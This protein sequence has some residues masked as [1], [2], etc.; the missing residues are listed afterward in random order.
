MSHDTSSSPRPPLSRERWIITGGVQGVGFRPFVYRCAQDAGVSG[1]VANTAEGVCLEIQGTS[2]QLEA[3]RQLFHTQLPP[4]AHIEELSCSPLPV[5]DAQGFRIAPSRGGQGHS[6]RISP[7]IALC[8]DCLREITDPSNRRAGYPFTNCTNCGPRYTITR[9]IPYDRATTSMACF[10]LCPQCHAEY[11]DPADRRFH[12]QPNACPTCGPRLWLQTARGDLVGQ[13]PQ[14]MDMAAH[15]LLQ[16][17]ILAIKGLGGFHLACD[18]RNPQAVALLRQRKRRPSKPLAIMVRDLDAARLFVQVDETTAALLTGIQRPIAVVPALPHTDLAPNLSP[19][20]NELGIMTAYTPLHYLLLCRMEEILG[21]KGVVVMTSGNASSEPIALGNRE[22]LQ[23]LATIADLFLLHDRDILIRCDDSVIRPL[24][25]T[26]HFLRRARGYTPAPI[27]LAEHGPCVLG[28]GPLLKNTLCVTK[29]QAAYVSQHIGDLEN[30]ETMGFFQEMAQHL[31][32]ILQ[33]RPQAI[34]H[35]LHPDFLSTRFAQESGITPCLAVQ[36]HTAHILAVLAENQTHGPVLGL[37]LDGAGL[38][39]DGT[40]W[41]GEILL[42]ETH[43]LRT[44]RLAHLAPVPMPGGDAASREPWRMALAYLHTIGAA[45]AGPWP[46]T[47]DHEAAQRIVQHML[48]RRVRCPLTTSCGRLFDAVASLLGL[49]QVLEYEGQGAIR[50]EHAQHLA[51]DRAYPLPLRPST[52]NILDSTALFAAVYQD[53]KRGAPPGV[54]ARRFHLGLVFGL[55]DALRHFAQATGCQRVALSGGVF[56][57]ATMSRL[58][59]ELLRRQGLTPIT[60]RHLPPG[61]G[62]ISLGQAVYGRLW[63]TQTLHHE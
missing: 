37:A 17:R 29:G 20:T 1:L 45:N 26:V 3:F 14:A 47:Q 6:V 51:E 61:D 39:E 8:N 34:V 24:E 31:P 28:V 15:S 27:A 54:I 32:A 63:L 46:W 2:S 18:A 56:H 48:S 10:P 25:G 58:L 41:G 22:A 30:L 38:G 57:N 40:V 49:C 43:P 12:A 44:T 23:R 42:V 21:K 9:A 53:W 59:P 11:H 55:A 62:C 35:D 4:L 50:L 16:G 5:E 13:G 36:H 52:P 19:D 60:H 33:V 7:D